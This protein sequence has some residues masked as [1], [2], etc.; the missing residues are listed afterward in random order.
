MPIRLTLPAALALLAACTDL[1]VN[2]PVYGPSAGL[3]VINGTGGTVSVLIDG[4][5]VTNNLGQATS[6][7]ALGLQPGSYTVQVQRS[8]VP[9]FPRT[10]DLVPGDT[11][12]LVALDS[13]GG[14]TP[15]VL[16]DTNAVVPAGA[17]KLRVA[18]MASSAP[19]ISIW[20]TQPDF[21][22]PSRVQFPFAYRAV[23]PYLQSTPGD[24]RVMVSS[25]DNT[26]GS[27][28]LSYTLA[29]TAVISALSLPAAS[30]RPVAPCKTP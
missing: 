22:S 4:V 12:T 18:H 30:F 15:A 17:S 11:A 10:I 19:P 24:W 2:N 16:A 26:S 8:G 27:V 1:S 28:P 3:R 6:S 14:I 29:N 23:S 25:E 13:A 20:R 21:A 7:G 5:A 9:G